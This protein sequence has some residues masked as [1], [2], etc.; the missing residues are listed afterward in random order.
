MDE[1]AHRVASL[2]EKLET[3]RVLNKCQ[4]LAIDALLMALGGI[5][6]YEASFDMA[7]KQVMKHLPPDDWEKMYWYRCRAWT[8]DDGG[9]NRREED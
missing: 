2:E 4:G 7:L 5:V 9:Y 3:L 6:K 8:A 1:L